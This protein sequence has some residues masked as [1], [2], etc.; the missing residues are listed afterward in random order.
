MVE[1][2]E[3]VETLARE[4]TAGSEAR[5]APR[6]RRAVQERKT[7]LLQSLIR[8]DARRAGEMGRTARNCFP[9]RSPWSLRHAAVVQREIELAR[10]VDPTTDVGLRCDSRQ[11]S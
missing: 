6:A 7:P 3:L 2:V 10:T 5:R 9:L 1:P 11:E 8:V 4:E